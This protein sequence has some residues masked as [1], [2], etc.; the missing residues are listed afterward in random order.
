[1][2]LGV[3]LQQ[4]IVWLIFIIFMAMGV[5]M[6]LAMTPRMDKFLFSKIKTHGSEYQLLY[7]IAIA[8]IGISFFGWFVLVVYSVGFRDLEEE[9][10]KMLGIPPLFFYGVAV[11]LMMILNH[12]SLKRILFGEYDPNK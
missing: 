3:V 4:N 8:W 10:S 9:A 6:M 7:D 1:M 11:I 2:G 5:S 12:Q